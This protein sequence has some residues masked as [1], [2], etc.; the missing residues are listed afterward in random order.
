MVAAIIQAR[1]G[2]TRFPGKV[3]QTLDGI[4][5]LEYLV[6]RLRRSKG[7]DEILIA[8]TTNQEDE[9]IVNL[10]EKLGVI[11]FRGSEDDV[12]SRFYYAS[13]KLKSENI[14]RV[15]GD[16]PLLDPE[17]VSQVIS[18]FKEKEVDYL[19]NTIEASFPDG[20]DVEIFT[21]KSLKDA[22]LHCNEKVMK[23]HVTTWIQKNENYKKFSYK[24]DIDYS[25]LRVT[26]DEPEDLTVIRS[27]VDS[28]PKNYFF[29][30]KDVINLYK[31]SP[32]IF[33]PNKKFKRNEGEFL[34]KGSKLWRRAKKIIPGG[35]MLL[36]KRS[37]MF[38]PEKWPAYFSSAKGCRII[39]LDGSEYI[40]M[41]IM[42]IGTNILGYA[43]K[44]VDEAVTKA[45]ASG[46]MSTFNCPEE[47][48]LAEKLIDMHPWAKMVKLARTGGE[49]NAISIRIA[50]A[51]TGRDKVAICGYHGWH[52][53]YL[54]SNIEDNNNLDGHLLAGLNPLGVPKGLKGSVLPFKYNDFDSIKEIVN[55][56]KLAAIKM[57]VER[58][59]P[60]KD[61]FLKKVRSLCT[62][63][64]IVLIFD[65]CTSGFRETYGG[66]HKKYNVNPDMAIFGKALGNGY[67]ITAI[68]GR[69][70]VMDSA[71]DSFISS[72]FWTERI[73]PVAAL[74][75]LE[76]MKKEQSWQQITSIGK[77]VKR[78]WEKLANKYKLEI[79]QSGIPSLA[80][81]NFKSNKSQEY[82]TFITQ[83]MLKNKFLASNLFYAC[84]SHKE[85]IVDEYFEKMD[86]IFCKIAECENDYQ[87]ILEL[88]ESPVSIS[89]F[90]RLN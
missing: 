69:E 73:G 29:T 65:E 70:S 58:S 63:K 17:I 83:E 43:N 49:A 78:D 15:T 1:M 56:N 85:Y 26:I 54:A 77:R 8:T 27:I 45:V 14:I 67:A 5:I 82:K 28:F 7:L 11:V 35:N 12:L 22:F 61:E 66:L 48:A 38:L 33:E 34:S 6:K 20:F 9:Q 37:E 80:C 46:N 16:C 53:W 2:S 40:D 23:E 89:G 4:S 76:V 79:M 71:Q 18:L 30:Y 57:E 90:K 72:T 21:K 68:I 64:G 44:E 25:S 87:N 42:G 55:K 62:E 32:E 24:N 50:R 86:N 47:V 75:T 59:E 81:F 52:D 51:A 60:P 10:G 3:L 84:L 31:K 41:S 88:L 36:S 19:S 74:K 39:D 13:L